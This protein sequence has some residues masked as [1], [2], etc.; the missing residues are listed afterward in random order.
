[1]SNILVAGSVVFSRLG[2]CP[3]LWGIQRN[4]EPRKLEKITTFPAILAPPRNVIHYLIPEVTKKIMSKSK[5]MGKLM[6]DG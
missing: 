5:G 4:C 1:M 6:L 3:Y 2:L